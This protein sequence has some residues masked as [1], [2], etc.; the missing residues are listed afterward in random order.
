MATYL[1][2]VTDYIP[3][4]QPFQPDLNFYGNVMQ[5]K[6]TQ[7][8]SNWKA[9]NKMYGQYYYA[10]LTRE[11]N[12]E[13][14]E[15]YLKNI[16]FQLKRVSQLDLSLEQNAEQA[17]QVFK[18]FYEDKGLMKDMAWTKNKNNQLNRAEIFK[19][20][21]DVKDKEQYWEDGVRGINYMT[22]EFKN[23]TADEALS[24]QNA[25]YV[26]YVNVIKK[27]NEIAEK[28][29]LNIETPSFSEDGKWMIKTR[30]GEAILEPLKDL[31]EAELGNDP[32]VQA[33]YKMQAYVDRKDYAYSNA[34][35]FGG[36]IMAAEMKYLENGFNTLKQQSD[37]RYR[38]LQE[39]SSVYDSKIKDLEDQV[40]NGTASPQVKQQLAQYKLNKEIVDKVLARA[41]E[42]NDIMNMDEDTYGSTSNGFINPYGD[43]KSLRFKVDNGMASMLMQKDLSQA[44][45]I[46]MNKNMKQEIAANPY[47]ILEQKKRD[48]LALISAKEKANNRNKLYEISVK[49]KIEDGTHTLNAFGQLVPVEE[50]NFV[51]NE[52]EKSGGSTAN[53]NMKNKS[54]SISQM[55]KEEYLDPY[56]HT[57]FAVLDKALKAGKISRKEVSKIL[58]YKGNENI[59]LEEFSK[60]YNQYGDAWLRKN[61]GKTGINTIKNRMNSWVSN[62]NQL[63]IF[64]TNGQKT[65]TYKMY[66]QA[67]QKM[68]EYQLYL[69]ED[70]KWRNATS[71]RV[72]QSLAKEGFK[73]AFLLYDEKGEL[74][75]EA[76][77]YDALKKHNI[78]TYGD[79]VAKNN[80][81]DKQFNRFA[82]SRQKELTE[83]YL[84]TI[85]GNA[86]GQRAAMDANRKT[87]IPE[88]YNYKKMVE[89]AG[90][91][92]MDKNVYGKIPA[93]RLGTGPDG[94]SG[95]SSMSSVITVNP[96]G[97]STGK[98]HFADVMND[99]KNFNW[100]GESDKVT[101]GGIGKSNYDNAFGDSKQIGKRLLED[102]KKDMSN[103][104]SKLGQFDIKVSPIAAGSSNK[105]AVIIK[106]NKEWLDQYLST[107]G[108]GKTPN[109]LLN[110]AIYNMILK[111]G[112]SFI[113]DSK[114]MKSSMY[115]NAFK[116]PLQAYVDN[117]ED[118]YRL[119]NIGGDPLKS[120][121][122]TKNNLGTGDY[123]T[124]ITWGVYNPTK[125]V[126]E[127]Q[128]YT[129]NI[130]FQGSNLSTNMDNVLYNFFDEIDYAN[131]LNLNGNY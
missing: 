78:G 6:Q 71:K 121:T 93:V 7:Y 76:E 34:A 100:F 104:K 111:N 62:N 17:T 54:R 24:F 117:N 41:K 19:V 103:P 57:T 69:S 72:E 122:I 110:A 108:E 129:N 91:A 124:N 96:R 21:T 20:S 102:L 36:D 118:G 55:T 70:T 80:V 98:A 115:R 9:L 43:I 2:G 53:I 128:T 97:V 11:D 109:N 22:E 48:S 49:Q 99:L 23:A 68:N 86:V 95:T 82:A 94:G 74:R 47:A 66:R 50:Q 85:E 89:A 127:Q 125:G 59:S 64:T 119:T 87:K 73:G 25:E 77:F 12:T 81:I 45:Q 4:F 56:M 44:A 51:R 27:A 31:F 63:T 58:G 26:P 61:V 105:S 113:T 5:T 126:M 101:F 116:S 88:E 40:A 35:Q 30:N 16:E 112:I 18:P 42:E 46:F 84:P 14:R 65:D 107:A 3:Q 60:K 32:A 131:T 92:Y 83:G 114:N 130:G 67:D 33:V 10:D 123:T 52:E 13:K 15:T 79:I 90:K 120:Y 75:S 8:D 106:P 37:Q 29:K 28:A 1:Q 38:S 39:N